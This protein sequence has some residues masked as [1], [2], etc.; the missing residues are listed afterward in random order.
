M[1]FSQFLVDCES[2]KQSSISSPPVKL[3]EN[4]EE[5]SLDHHFPLFQICFQDNL[6]EDSIQIVEEKGKNF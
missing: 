6:K 3:K 4:Y 2:T 5:Q 1:N